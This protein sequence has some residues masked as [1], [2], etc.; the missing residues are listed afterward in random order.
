MDNKKL[1]LI[2]KFMNGKYKIT[3]LKKNNYNYSYYIL[4]NNELKELHINRLFYNDVIK[5][6]SKSK[7]NDVFMDMMKNI[8]AELL[9]KSSG[10]G[11][12]HNIRVALFSLIICINENIP[13]NDFK[14]IIDGAKYHDIGRENDLTDDY[15]G[16]RSAMKMDFLKS[17]YSEEELNNL[18]TIVTCH[19][20]DDE[21][22]DSVA[23]KYKIKDIDRCRK[24]LNVLK[25]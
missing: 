9:Y 17:K 15:H 14:I 5:I 1:D 3:N 23:K 25:D 6:L 21:K 10:H 11:I 20:L 4:A 12:N 22:F 13:L 16:M 24:M 2:N 7:Y 19:S 8:R 18:K